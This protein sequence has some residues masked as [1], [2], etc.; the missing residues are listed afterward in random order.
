MPHTTYA[1]FSAIRS[2]QIESPRSEMISR[3]GTPN[4][5][6]L[7]HLDK[8]LSWTRDTLFRW[9]GQKRYP[10][11]AEQESV[12]AAALWLLQGN[13][14]QR[15]VTAWHVGWEPARRAS[16]RSWLAPLQAQLLDDP[17]GVVREV[18]AR[19]LR[20]LPG[21]TDFPYDFLAPSSERSKKREEALARWLASPEKPDRT[22]D[23]VLIGSDGRPM[24]AR[25]REL[26][27]KRDN[28]PITIQE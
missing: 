17:Y 11:T 24:E 6:N 5:C 10:M 4:A 22:G 14:A 1:L 12:S 20:S 26:L 9:Y 21:F 16:G 13:A 3:F 28:R 15:V 8:T 25:Y 27:G 7:C 23:T 19:S 2:H 18:G